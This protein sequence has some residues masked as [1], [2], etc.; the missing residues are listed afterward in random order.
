MLRRA[1]LVGRQLGSTISSEVFAVPL[2]CRAYEQPASS[3]AAEAPSSSRT[4]GHDFQETRSRMSPVLRNLRISGLPDVQAAIPEP[5]M[6]DPT[7]DSLRTALIAVKVG[8]VSE[9]DEHG[10]LTPMTVLW[11]DDNQVRP[12]RPSE[13]AL[14][15]VR[16]APSH[17]QGH[18]HQ[19]LAPPH[20]SSVAAMPERS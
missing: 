5:V 6:R 11:F 7:P 8:M 14:S 16:A 18:S 15:S 2:G 9:W 17:A 19:R 1:L 13:P 20:T 4:T 12:P 10:V 3:A